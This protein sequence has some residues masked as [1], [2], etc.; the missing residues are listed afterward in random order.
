[1]YSALDLADTYY[2]IGYYLRHKAEIDEY[3]KEGNQT[4][5]K[6]GEE[7][8]TRYGQAELRQK[9]KARKSLQG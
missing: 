8:K 7:L 3:L 2:A 9:L 4:A 5:D 1:M 6:L